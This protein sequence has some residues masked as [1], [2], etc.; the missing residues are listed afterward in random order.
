MLRYSMIR[1]LIVLAIQLVSLLSCT[2]TTADK[3]DDLFT[4]YTGDN[5]GASVMVI[6]K[7]ETVVNKSYGLSDLV[8]NTAVTDS[9]NFRLASVTKQFTAMSI[10]QLIDS[11]RI[12]FDTGLLEIFPEFPDYAS[13]INYRQ[14]LHHTSGIVDY[15]SLIP[16][17]LTLPVLDIDV[18]D[19]L[20][21]TDSTY[22]E[23]GTGYSY[24]NSGYAILALT[25]ER[26]TGLSFPEYLSK[27]I[28]NPLGMNGSLAYVRDA[29]DFSNRALGYFVDQGRNIPSDQSMTSSV[30]GDGGIYSSTKDLFKWDQALYGTELLSQD[31]LDSAF[32]PWLENYGCG[33]RIEDYKG[34][35][36]ISHTGSTCGFR[37]VYQR[38]PA[39]EFSIII[40][41]NR[42]DPGVQY[43]AEA[44]TDLY[45]IDK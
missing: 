6:H 27:Y 42:R 1:I 23:P 7:G 5:P 25:V 31:L 39:Y 41:T 22:F 37:T 33:W 13:T 16:N 19:M 44:I 2:L 20:M 32:T 11:G 26:I 17:T 36:R 34:M 9:S 38:F 8:R 4:D 10:L 3:I 15:E 24:S 29:P 12:D 45:L 35:Q 43:L 18:L 28:F 30:L 40:L 21:K 14:L